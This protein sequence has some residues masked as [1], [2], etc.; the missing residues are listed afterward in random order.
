V[1][2]HV[3]WDLPFE[4][5]AG[6]E[7]QHLMG[8]TDDWQSPLPEAA[9]ER[10]VTHSV[11]AG[12]AHTPTLVTYARAARLDDPAAL[13]GDAAAARLPAFYRDRLWSLAA[14]PLLE[15]L[16]PS[17]P[18]EAR[19]RVEQM[20]RLVGRLRAAG[21]RV[22]A[23]S[24]VMNP[25]V[26]PGAGLQ[27]ELGQLVAAGFT[28]EEALALASRGAGEA[29]RVPELGRLVPGAPADL[30]IYRDDPTRDLT[31][32]ATLEAVVAAGRLYT[33]EDLRAAAERLRAHA[34]AFPYGPL[35]DL[36]ARAAI[37][38]VH[39]AGE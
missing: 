26:V 25:Y 9:I 14:N 37:A 22:L 2:A 3:P 29:L 28:P 27:E 4:R 21:V 31:A 7:V 15:R 33:V 13:A 5:V 19:A 12:L 17:G 32:L 16:V 38:A 24:D 18:P 30:G 39:R 34:D 11:R 36:A 23:G 35:A 8:L 6:V 20:R 1:V 10:Y